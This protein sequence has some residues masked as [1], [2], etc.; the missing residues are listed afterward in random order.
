MCIRNN[1]TIPNM[2]FILLENN[3][4]NPTYLLQAEEIYLERAGPDPKLRVSV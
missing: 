4:T 2:L 3:L 1:Q